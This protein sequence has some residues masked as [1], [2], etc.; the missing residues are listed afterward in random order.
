MV[1]SNK[2]FKLSHGLINHISQK[3]WDIRTSP[4][5]FRSGLE[6]QNNFEKCS[7]TLLWIWLKLIDKSRGQGRCS[8]LMPIPYYKWNF[9]YWN[10]L[11]IFIHSVPPIPEVSFGISIGV[12]VW[13][14]SPVLIW[15]RIAAW[16]QYWYGGN[17]GTPLIL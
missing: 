7:I 17:G 12:L 2:K 9:S 6:V 1:Y 10:Y 14:I 8:T 16:Y 5:L 11:K 15:V 3:V 13:N 4:P